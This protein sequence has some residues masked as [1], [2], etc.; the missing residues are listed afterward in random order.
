MW[1]PQAYVGGTV[2]IVDNCDPDKWLK[3]EIK[4]ICR[5]FGYIAVDKLWF[6]M[7][8]VNPEQAHFH[9]VVNDDAAV[10]MTN[11]V[12]GYGDLH[13]FVDHRVNEPVEL[14]MEDLEPL[15]I[16]SPGSE[17]KW[18]NALEVFGGDQQIED[19]VYYVSS[20]N[21]LQ[22]D[23]FYEY[24]E[25]EEDNDNEDDDGEYRLDFSQF[26]GHDN[27]KTIEV[28]HGEPHQEDAEQVWDRKAGKAL[29]VDDQVKESGEA[30]GSD[31]KE[32]PQMQP[33]DIGEDNT[34]SWDNQ[35][36]DDEIE[37]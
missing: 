7:P 8:S 14:P 6:K 1:D 18:V 22:S 5:D 35:A 24:T 29:V 19:V 26:R 11:L 2:D 28:D 15:A 30:K 16:R 4:R 36:E 13:V 21:E 37:Q 25:Y 32:E 12:K 20:D 17:P 10:F 33:M 31:L 9:E 34:N 3:V 23:H 27:A